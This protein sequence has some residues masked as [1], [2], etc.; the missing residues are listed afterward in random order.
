MG[1]LIPMRANIPTA[2]SEAE[3]EALK[4]LAQDKTVLEVGAWY[5]FS[6]VLM[7]QVAS[8]V[9]SID[10]H[11]G[12]SRVG[13]VDTS[14]AYLDNLD[15]WRVRRKVVSL[16]GK[17][18][19]V[20]PFLSPGVFDLGFIDADHD[21]PPVLKDA[22]MCAMLGI[23]EICFHDYGRK[24]PPGFEDLTEAVEIFAREQMARVEVLAGTLAVVRWQ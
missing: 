10:W 22:R 8:V 12:D 15:I 9:W 1:T 16:F 7:G 17:T 5:G 13:E 23:H 4:S 21:G 24:D 14:R 3:A 2:L 18:E 11:L 19:E 20:L 6:T